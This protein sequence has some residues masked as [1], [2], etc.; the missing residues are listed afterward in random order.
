M[1][2]TKKL[3]LGLGLG[4]SIAAYSQS[5]YTVLTGAPFLRISPDARAGGMGDQGVATSTDV[6]SQFWNAA[7]YP[8]AKNTSG[9]GVNYTPYMSKLTNDVFLLYGSFYTFLGD[10]ERSTLSASIYYFNMGQVDLTSLVGNEVISGGTTKPNEFSIDVAYGLKLSDY[11]SMAVTGRFIR[12][13]L[14]GSFNSDNT[15]Q[16]ANTFAVDVSGYYRSPK[17]QSIGDYEGRVNAGWAVQNLGP[18]L[19][20][21]GDENSRSYL[22]TM[23][24]L[25]VGYDLFIDDLNRF[26]ISGEASKLL[27]PGPE[28]AEYDANGKPVF[29]IPNVGVMEGIGKSFGNKKSIMFSGAAEYSYDDAFAIRAGYFTESPEQGAR[30]YATVGVGLKYQSFGLDLSYLVNMSKVNSALDNTLRFGLTW[31]I[32]GETYNSQ[33]Y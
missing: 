6:F 5:D 22:P 17:H 9:V 13:D 10:D 4:M 15:L 18:R 32:G 3:F 11:Y 7:K 31:N 12:S 2:F 8:F 33:D 19:D 29:R 23:A 30:Q 20:Y 21:T 1:N 16:P 27:V 28:I 25:G 24:R 14:G 26:S